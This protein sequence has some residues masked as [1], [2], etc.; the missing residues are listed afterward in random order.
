MAIFTAVGAPDVR[1]KQGGTRAEIG[2]G[3]PGGHKQRQRRSTERLSSA[4]PRSRRTPNELAT[5]IIISQPVFLSKI[6]IK[7]NFFFVFKA[8]SM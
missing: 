4:S 1:R 6:S 7:S 2:K 5:G 8:D 3:L